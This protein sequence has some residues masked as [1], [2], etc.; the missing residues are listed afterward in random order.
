M[1]QIEKEPITS[2][3]WINK[4]IKDKTHIDNTYI[5]LIDTIR[6]EE[7]ERIGEAALVFGMSKKTQDIINM[8]ERIASEEK[9]KINLLEM[10]KRDMDCE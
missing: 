6:K 5:K 7:I 3:E 10:T 8:I 4:A 1:A 9:G 2:C